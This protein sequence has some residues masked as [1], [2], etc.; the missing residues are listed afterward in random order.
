MAINEVTLLQLIKSRPPALDTFVSGLGDY[1]L[2]K[3]E[4]AQVEN[5]IAEAVTALSIPN[6]P[7]SKRS[8]V[9]VP[10][11]F[12][13]NYYE[14]Y[15]DAFLGLRIYNRTFDKFPNDD[16]LENIIY[17]YEGNKVDED[18]FNSRSTPGN[19]TYEVVSNV[20]KI[21]GNKYSVL[22]FTELDLSS[23]NSGTNTEYIDEILGF[24]SQVPPPL[25]KFTRGDIVLSQGT[26]HIE[27]SEFKTFI[28]GQL[29]DYRDENGYMEG[30][31]E[32]EIINP[33]PY[34]D[35]IAI[36]SISLTNE[37]LDPVIDEDRYIKVKN[38]TATLVIEWNTT[39]SPQTETEVPLPTPRWNFSEIREGILNAISVEEVG[40]WI[41]YGVYN[42]PVDGWDKLNIK[43]AIS[44]DRLRHIGFIEGEYETVASTSI[45][46]IRRKWESLILENDFSVLESIQSYVLKSQY[47]SDI[48]VLPER[49]IGYD[50]L[51]NTSNTV[52]TLN[53]GYDSSSLL[54]SGVAEALAQAKP[55]EKQIT[56][57]S[58]DT[59]D[60]LD[61]LNIAGVAGGALLTASVGILF[62]KIGGLVDDQYCKTTTATED[63]VESSSG[64]K[65][66]EAKSAEEEYNESFKTDLESRD[67]FLDHNVPVAKQFVNDSGVFNEDLTSDDITRLLKKMFK[68]DSKEKALNWFNQAGL[69]DA[70]ATRELQKK[71]DDLLKS[72]DTELIW[73]IMLNEMKEIARRTES[74]QEKAKHEEAKAERK[75]EQEAEKEARKKSRAASKE[76]NE[77]KKGIKEDLRT[78]KFSE[79]PLYIDD[80]VELME[81]NNIDN[82]K[83]ALIYSFSNYYKKEDAIEAIESTIDL[84]RERN[85][86]LVRLLKNDIKW[87][88]KMPVRFEEDPYYWNT[89]YPLLKNISIWAGNT[90]DR[91]IRQ[92]LEFIFSEETRKIA[93]EDTFK[94]YKYDAD[95]DNVLRNELQ[96]P[97]NMKDRVSHRLN[98][99][100]S[101]K[102]EY[103]S[104]DKETKKLSKALKKLGKK[105]RKKAQALRSKLR[106]TLKSQLSKLDPC[107][108]SS[109]ALNQGIK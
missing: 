71:T 39:V 36:L 62:N 78:A 58:N 48:E 2:N 67:L 40:G 108:E 66:S 27:Y 44:D 51:D 93:I 99:G 24:D 109:K 87:P 38:Y 83:R 91:S 81:S 45:E 20:N 60:K 23:I 25:L 103:E 9:Q 5:G 41:F 84:K 89:N 52:N 14:E 56:S 94:K 7:F 101:R 82:A 86:T 73:P 72:F 61:L 22:N 96:W 16:E 1:T 34:L 92:Y 98:P 95:L 107:K 26:L 46:V 4:R 68:F 35:L 80:N 65:N 37:G 28:E 47:L 42:I 43:A 50:Q 97:P 105:L 85:T 33:P 19:V 12:Y 102:K 31:V 29:K 63:K 30:T 70:G 49:D 75:K 64:G 8:Q 21:I 79:Y 90:S 59:E 10:Y 88:P 77:Y 53:S 55:A 76:R 15:L 74:A 57:Y 3:V 69:T 11:V 17:V 6:R 18:T 54:V 32:V 13:D 106:D 100:G 104:V